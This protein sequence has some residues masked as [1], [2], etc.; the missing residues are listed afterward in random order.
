MVNGGGTLNPTYLWE[1]HTWSAHQSPLT[2]DAT[3]RRNGIRTLYWPAQ[4]TSTQRHTAPR[5]SC[6]GQ[7]V[8]CWRS[9]PSFKKRTMGS[10]SD[11]RIC[12]GSTKTTSTTNLARA[13][14]GGKDLG[15]GMRGSSN[16][17]TERSATGI[18][19]GILALRG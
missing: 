2:T 1:L 15:L 17:I 18:G 5:A 8:N 9:P 3:R 14:F 19:I 7:S 10:Q 13:S 16:E 6:T 11:P 12:D 4:P